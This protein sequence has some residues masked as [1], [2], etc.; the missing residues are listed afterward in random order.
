MGFLPHLLAASSSITERE[1]LGQGGCS[2]NRLPEEGHPLGALVSS[3]AWVRAP[4]GGPEQT[5]PQ[6]AWFGPRIKKIF[7][8]VANI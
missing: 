5:Q 8:I 1:A 4:A 3:N 7:L 6:Q 2:L